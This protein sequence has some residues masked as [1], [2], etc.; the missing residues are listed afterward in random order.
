MATKN[1]IFEIVNCQ[2]KGIA[3]GIYSACTANEEF[4]T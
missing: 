1:P 3:N 4:A 2:K